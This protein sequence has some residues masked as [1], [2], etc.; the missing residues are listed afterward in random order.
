MTALVITN[1]SLE[2]Q[3]E[4]FGLKL[5]IVDNSLPPGIQQ[6]HLNINASLTGLYE[7]PENDH[8]VSAIF[9]FR[10]EPPCRFAKPIMVEIQHCACSHN[11]SKLKFVRA[12]CSQKVHPFTFRKVIGGVFSSH[13]SFGILELTTFSGL[14]VSQEGSEERNYLANILYEEERIHN[15]DLCFHL[16]FVVTWDT[17]VHQKV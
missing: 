8:L 12:V 17:P 5:H 16:Y 9:W 13:S 10:C 15:S 11:T 4:S 14:G 2:W 3:W 6:Y 7:F 1:S